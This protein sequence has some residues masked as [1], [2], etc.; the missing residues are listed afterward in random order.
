MTDAHKTSIDNLISL[1]SDLN[2]GAL[3]SAAEAIVN[4]HPKLLKRIGL[5]VV[6][7][8]AGEDGT[9]KHVIFTRHPAFV[10]AFVCRFVEAVEPM[11]QIFRI[12]ATLHAISSLKNLGNSDEP[13]IAEQK[14]M[15]NIISVALEKIKSWKQQ[16]YFNSEAKSDEILTFK[17]RPKSESLSD[18]F[19]EIIDS[20]TRETERIGREISKELLSGGGMPSQQVLVVEGIVGEVLEG[21]WIPL[22]LPGVQLSQHQISRIVIKLSRRGVG[23]SKAIIILSAILHSQNGGA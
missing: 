7:N 21:E 23:S 10:S 6:L 4:A 17:H 13:V 1:G 12:K 15:G 19:R 22:P 20:T 2:S 11:G 18:M 14:A 9:S 3:A 5:S 8:E 16:S